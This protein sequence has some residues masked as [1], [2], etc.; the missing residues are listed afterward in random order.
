MFCIKMPQK[1]PKTVFYLNPVIVDFFYFYA[2][3][4]IPVEREFFFVYTVQI[5]GQK[6]VPISSYSKK[7]HFSL[8]PMVKVVHEI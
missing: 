7:T 1:S 4:C 8:K 5:L 6:V 3:Y 2:S